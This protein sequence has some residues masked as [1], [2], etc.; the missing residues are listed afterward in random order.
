E[1]G[2]D[3]GDLVGLAGD[4][5]GED[6]RVVAAGH[7]GQRVGLADAGLLQVVAVE[8]ETEDRPTGEA[9]GEPAKG[10][11]VLV[12]D[13]HRVAVALE[14]QGQL[15]AHPPATHHHNVHEAICNTPSGWGTT[16]R[17]IVPRVYVMLK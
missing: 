16:R 14:R 11:A 12:D 13:G 6:V 10:V 3:V 5:R 1:A 9:L 2:H 8:A 4:P 7:R 17:R 15:G